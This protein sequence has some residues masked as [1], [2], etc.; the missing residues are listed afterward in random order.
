MTVTPVLFAL[1]ITLTVAP[2]TGADEALQF[3]LPDLDGRQFSLTEELG[4]GPLVIGFWATWCKPCVKELPQLQ[5]I[6]AD[7]EERGVRAAN[8][9][10]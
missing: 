4:K 5:K 3:V 6:A 1:A 10:L 7:Y 8:R 9:F 2:P